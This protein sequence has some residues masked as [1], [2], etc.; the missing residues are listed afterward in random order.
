VPRIDGELRGTRPER[1]ATPRRACSV[2]LQ[3]TDGDDS[4]AAAALALEHSLGGVR[5]LLAAPAP[6]GGLLRVRPARSGDEEPWTELRVRYCRPDPGGGW[7]VGCQFCRTP[8]WTLF[9]SLD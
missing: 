9:V 7:Q 3:V 4:W 5:L 1:R 6:V 8:P 2:Q